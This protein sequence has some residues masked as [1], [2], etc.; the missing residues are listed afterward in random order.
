MIANE[1]RRMLCIFFNMTGFLTIMRQN[2][3]LSKK[4]NTGIVPNITCLTEAGIGIAL[5][6]REMFANR[7]NLSP[8]ILENQY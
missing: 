2:R 1:K 7:E 8:L 5:S 6:S 3:E 4:H